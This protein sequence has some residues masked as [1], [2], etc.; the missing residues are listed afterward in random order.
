MGKNKKLLKRLLDQPKGFTYAELKKLM[1]TFGFEE[2]NKGKSSG[3]RVAFYHSQKKLIL[4]LHKPHPN[5]E[6]KAYQIKE[7]IEFL[8]GTGDI[9]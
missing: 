1:F 2:D 6:L 8:K 5:N 3:S 4:R 9:Q 7:I